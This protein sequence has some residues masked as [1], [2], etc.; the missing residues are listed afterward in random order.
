MSL[1]ISE[2]IDSLKLTQTVKEGALENRLTRRYIVSGSDDSTDA[3]VQALGPQIGDGYLTGSPPANNLN[4]YC[5][6]REYD[7][8]KCGANGIVELTAVYGPPWRLPENNSSTPSTEFVL[9]T[10]S[11][12]T[13]TALAQT[14]YPSTA[15]DVGL[16]VNFT[17]RGVMGVD[18]IVKPRAVLNSDTFCSARSPATINS[19]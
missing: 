13:Q 8:K 5:I 18:D 6:H 11:A 3:A 17:D 12:H 9:Q 2:K 16:A 10:E 4:L 19:R 15:D 1:T 14:H 7:V